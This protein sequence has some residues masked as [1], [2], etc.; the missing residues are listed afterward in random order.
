MG[1]TVSSAAAPDASLSLTIKTGPS[2]LNQRHAFDAKAFVPSRC[3]SQIAKR[4]DIDQCEI[5]SGGFG[6]VF[7]ARDREMKSRTVAIKKVLIMD[8][9]RKKVFQREAQ[10]MKEL[11]HPSICKL[12]ETYEDRCFMFFVMEYC[13]GKDV[14]DRIME[15]GLIQEHAAAG[16]VKQTASALLYAHNRGIAHRDL[17]PE[18]LCYCNK[19]VA[20][21]HI[22]L[23]DWGLGSH[24]GQVK[25]KST[26]G[27][28]TYAA[29]EVLEAEET[30][31]YTA[32]CD[33]WSL[34]VV[35]YVMLCGKPPF[36][37]DHVQ[38][39]SG[40]KAETYPMTD[41][42]WAAIS[43]DAKDLIRGLL[44]YD[45]RTRLD[46]AKVLS[47]P[48]LRTH[49]ESQMDPQISGHVLGN[50]RRFSNSNHFFAICA[51]AVA[52]Q[53]DHKSLGD[54]RKV[55]CEMDT[56][57]DGVLQLHEIKLGFEALY[58]KESPEGQDVERMFARLDL[59]DSGTIDYNEFC[60]GGMGAGVWSEE[61]VVWAAFKAFDVVDDNG[62]ISREEIKQL[63]SS[64]DVK[65][66][67]DLGGVTE[68]IFKQFDKDRDGSL[69][70]AEWLGLMR[71][72]ATR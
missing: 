49:A 22:K 5:G 11:D 28:F 53:S 35:A 4:Y 51:A 31:A 41:V 63:L 14:L 56:N 23:V 10:I 17:K 36:W 15:D 29:P 7:V 27:S 19:D 24:F 18:N 9:E 72:C 43:P 60:A 1:C 68:E 44:K 37:G 8:E 62:R 20:E 48:W 38:I 12:L 57:G 32:A 3:N 33:I 67:L 54:L 52:R 26:V 21:N 70:F 59:D 64:G 30:G 55:F 39:L 2:L 25:M 34:G 40:M 13:E 69:D 58:G 65:K 50:L 61:K 46:L 66:G 6:K 71:E 45:P 16:I 42:T 47:S